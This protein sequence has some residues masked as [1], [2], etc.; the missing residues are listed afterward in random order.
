MRILLT[1]DD[2]I[3][4][5]GLVA[6]HKA[7][8]DMGEVHV[9]APATPQSATGHG[10]TV[11]DELVVEPVEVDGAFWGHSVEGRPADCVKLARRELMGEPMDLVLS[12]INAGANVGINVLYSGTVAAAAEGAILRAK[13][14]AF[15]L[16]IGDIEPDFDQAAAYCRSVL[17]TLLA[18][19]LAAGQLVSVNLPCQDHGPPTGVRVDRQ[20][21]STVWEKYRT[22]TDAKGRT[23]YQLTD[24]YG[25]A[26]PI[27]NTDVEALR[28]RHISVTPLH[29]D[30]T[31]SDR[32]PILR[33]LRF[34]IFDFRSEI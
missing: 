8:E 22:Y 33:G 32:M 21:V 29:V 20:S 1:N 16:E 24:E 17:D 7:V 11:H 26:D 14:V 31:D 4:A 15:S 30:L 13:A 5:P 18:G 27:D 19:D 10:I 34:S 28:E 2:G 6:L 25:F 23:C 12:G 3:L 9:V